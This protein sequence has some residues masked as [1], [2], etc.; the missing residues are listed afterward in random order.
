MAVL[1]IIDD[2]NMRGIIA[3]KSRMPKEVLEDMI[4]L[5][6]LSTSKAARKTAVRLRAK[7]WTPLS[8]IARKR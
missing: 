7:S 3:P 8:K 5:A 6:E 2:K 1:T 4:D